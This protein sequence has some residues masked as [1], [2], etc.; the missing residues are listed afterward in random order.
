MSTPIRLLLIEDND[1]DAA[2]IQAF[3]EEGGFMPEIRRVQTTG[4]P[5]A[6]RSPGTPGRGHIGLRSA[7]LRR[8]ASAGW[9][10]KESDGDTPFI[11][12]SGGR[13]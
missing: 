1:D 12:I 9:L 13:G 6:M 2:L 10:F 8:F 7:R 4:K 3:L 5:F 11:M